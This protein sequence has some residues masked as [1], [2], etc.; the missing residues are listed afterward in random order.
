M[1]YGLR[2]GL[3]YCVSDGIAVFLDVQ[4]DRY[5]RLSPPLER[6][7][8]SY[9]NEGV[10]SEAKIQSLIGRGVLAPDLANE[11]PI[12]P[13]RIATATRSAVEMPIPHS[14]IGLI[15]EVLLTTWSV[16]RKIRTR[17]LQQVLDT[18]ISERSRRLAVPEDPHRP[19]DWLFATLGRFRR[20]RLHVPIAPRCLLDS[21]VLTRFLARRGQESQI[22]FGVVPEPFSAHCW[23]QFGETVLND[24]VGSAMTHTPIRVI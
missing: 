21:L 2:D 16:Q 8:L 24:T 19:D 17:P 15:P 10:A 12:S 3:T 22:V 20:A 4:S 18:V 14:G 1:R 6:A 9:A 5:F 7:F 23:V 11:R 13:P